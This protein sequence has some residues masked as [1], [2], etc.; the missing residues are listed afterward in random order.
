MMNLVTPRISVQKLQT[1]LQAK[2]KAEP[3]YRFYSLW[4]KICRLDVLEEA[5]RRCRA[6]RGSP[7]ADGITFAQ[8]ET[9]GRERWLENVR[10]E[11]TAGDYRPQPLLRVWIPKS[12]GG[13][14]PLSIPTVKDR[15]VMTAAMLVIGAIFEADLLENQ[16][17]FRPKVDA[18][19]AVR[20]VFWHIRDH[21]RSEIVDADL[22]DYFTSIPHAPLMKC[23][24]RRIADGRL[25][26]MIKGWLTVAVIEK[27]G[28]RIT[29]T[30][31]ARTKKRGTPQGSPL[32]PL[33]ANL[34]FRRFLLAWR[35]HG[36][37]DQLDAHIVNYADD[38]VICC[39]P[40]S[41]ETAMARMQTLMNRLGL[42]VNDTKT[43][44]ARVPEDSVTFLGYTIGRF[45]G[46]GG[47]AFLGTRPSKKAVRRLLRQ[48]HDRTTRQ[49]Y[50]DSPENTVAVINRFLR[51][52]C[53]YFDQGPVVET[54]NLI[55]QYV[56]RRLRHWLV[57]R[58]GAR[59]RGFNRY[60]QEY[61]HETLGLYRLPRARADVPR[62]KA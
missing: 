50:P 38:F 32:S 53:G 20:R 52:W 14:R 15:T 25:L 42:E 19:M 24:T 21:R 44:L 36:H 39:R 57:Q 30:A 5:Y 40:G 41:S 26:S 56:D 55:R 4:D 2:A 62:A 46:K 37:Q 1:S 48:V 23:L 10:Q 12:N 58:T 8:I 6:N 43:R 28:R 54:Y 49:W 11:L 17:G 61:L 59:G 29:R 13:R 34:Y 31:E 3:D 16:Y 60:S 18:K 47:Q 22:R 33:L 51:G 27:D 9:E 35:K 45:Y 7:G